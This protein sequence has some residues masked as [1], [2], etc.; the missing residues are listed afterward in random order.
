VSPT[1]L[2]QDKKCWMKI[3]T[4]FCDDYS[5]PTNFTD[6]Y[7]RKHPEIKKINNLETPGYLPHGDV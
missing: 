6:F 5:K 4:T 3:R 7:L 1:F 2:K